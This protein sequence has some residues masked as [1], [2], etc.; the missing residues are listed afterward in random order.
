GQ[1]QAKTLTREQI[2]DLQKA[3]SLTKKE[4]E[5]LYEYY[6]T[7]YSDGKINKGKFTRNSDQNSE[8]NAIIFNTVKSYAA[9]YYVDGSKSTGTNIP[10]NA[11][12]G[13]GTSNNNN[14]NKQAQTRTVEDNTLSIDSLNFQEVLPTLMLC[15]STSQESKLDWGFHMFAS[16]QRQKSNPNS[17]DREALSET[18]KSIY[19]SLSDKNIA[20]L[21]DHLRDPDCCLEFVLSKTNPPPASQD[22]DAQKTPTSLTKEQFKQAYKQK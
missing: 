4:V 15:D 13:E 3:T 19:K 11:L 9:S 12:K 8:L 18:F 22:Q 6:T 17:I 16:S 2:A 7:Q 5:E 21:P 14:I 1:N 20:N 10:S